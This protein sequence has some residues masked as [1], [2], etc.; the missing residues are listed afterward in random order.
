MEYSQADVDE[1]LQRFRE[2]DATRTRLDK[3]KEKLLR[4][5]DADN[6]TVSARLKE[7]TS[8][9]AALQ[10]SIKIAQ[11]IYMI[12]KIKIGER[13]LRDQTIQYNS[14]QA[15]VEAAEDVYSSLIESRARQERVDA[16]L[17]VLF[18][19]EEERDKVEKIKK[20]YENGMAHLKHQ[21]RHAEKE[22]LRWIPQRIVQ[23]EKELDD[24]AADALR[25]LVEPPWVTSYNAKKIRA[26]ILE[27]KDIFLKEL[28]K[29]YK[30][31]ALAKIIQI[32]IELCENINHHLT[33][34]L[35][36]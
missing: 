7:I 9:R 30:R 16:A 19:S 36:E 12:I 22:A 34:I 26:E 24:T 29:S 35:S 8:E 27:L 20:S 25:V 14:A 28:K 11:L 5:E 2:L 32:P 31:L 10:A 4:E 3:E 17:E 13:R 15:S 6:E 1:A 33:T 21:R 18:D 23:L